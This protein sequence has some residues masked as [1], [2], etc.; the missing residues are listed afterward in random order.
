MDRSPPADVGLLGR[1]QWRGWKAAWSTAVRAGADGFVVSTA[2]QAFVEQKTGYANSTVLQAGVDLELF[3]P[4]AKRPTTTMVYHGR[5]DRHRGVLACAMLAQKARLEGLEVDVVFV[6]EG[7]LMASLTTLTEA[8]AFIHV[9]GTMPQGELAE[10]LGTCHLGLL[11]MPK[12]TVWALASPLKRSE[13]LASGLPVFGIDHE[14]HQ[15]DG[16]DDAWFSLVPQEDFHLDGLEVLR[17]LVERPTSADGP[18]TYAQHRLAWT[19]TVDRLAGVLTAR[20][21]KV[22]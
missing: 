6:G 22:S 3:K 17:S 11:P 1:L 5:L 15:L 16:V 9:H 2:H 19:A 12:R 13:Y 10:L 7:D 8:N 20:Q 4:T 18:R 21:R 14:G